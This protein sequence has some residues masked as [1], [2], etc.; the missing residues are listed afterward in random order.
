MTVNVTY[1]EAGAVVPGSTTVKNSPLSNGE[2]DG[3]F[4]SVKD[5][6]ELIQGS[7]GAANVGFSPVGE[8][9][10]TTVQ[11]AIAELDSEKINTANLAA[12]S[13]S[14]LVGYDGGT[15]QDVL[16][17]VTG[18]TGAG[19]VGYMPAGTG[20]VATTVQEKLRDIPVSLYEFGGAFEGNCIAAMDLALASGATQ[21]VVPDNVTLGKHTITGD[22]VTIIGGRNVTFSAAV[23]GAGFRIGSCDRV[24]IVG[25]QDAVLAEFP[26]AETNITNG[27]LFIGLDSVATVGE[28]FVRNN[29]LSGGRVGISLGFESGKTLL[30][31]CEIVGNVCKNQNGNV[32]GAGYG[33]HYINRNDTGVALIANNLVEN[34]GRHSYYVAGNKGGGAVFFNCNKVLNHRENSTNKGSGVRSAIIIGRSSN[35]TGFGNQVNGYYDSAL[36]IAEEGEAV[37]NPFNTDNVTLS[38]TI[39]R[40]PKNTTSAIYLGYLIPSASAT[41]NNVL[42][43]G[44]TF[45]STLAGSQLL[46]YAW[47]RNVTIKN[48]NITYKDVTSVTTRMFALIG[49]DTT[50]TKGLTLENVAVSLINCTGTFSIMRPVAP[51]A[52]SDMPLSVRDVRLVNNTAGAT[53]NEWEPAVAVTNPSI[54]VFGYSFPTA[55]SVKPKQIR[56]PSGISVIQATTTWDPPSVAA[57]SSTILDA[58]VTGA[59][60]NDYAVASF[61]V[62]VG[63]LSISAAIIGSNAVRVRLSNN[64]ASAVDLASGTLS[65]LVIKQI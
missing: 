19:S 54:D 32:A 36:M 50:V 63:G 42:L 39:I 57:G 31:R 53:V 29:T 22:K 38:G 55:S 18:P 48:V 47:G 61:S 56:F 30:G 3:N 5:A 12:S 60:L 65:I 44:V 64:T 58:T 26:D 45:E 20:A 59:A 21:I 41:T 27:H 35:V 23:D 1:R 34:A 25:F 14:S 28:V 17:E 15:V 46:Y 52:T 43:D 13:G 24:E 4:K 7:S 2:I 33:I 16:D 40:N 6:V 62:N 49:Y 11:A 9:A 51:F 37:A 8:V 10:A